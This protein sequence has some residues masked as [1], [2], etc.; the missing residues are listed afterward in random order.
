VA[1]LIEIVGTDASLRA[2][3]ARAFAR[4]PGEWSVVVL[5][6]PSGDADVVVADAT[7][8]S[9]EAVTFDPDRP[10]EAL[11]EAGARLSALPPRERARTLLVAGAAGG[12]GTTTLALHLAA[13]WGAGTCVCDVAG[14]AARSLGLPGDART[15]LPHDDDVA[16][17]ALPVAGGFRVL[18]APAPVP[19]PEHFP[20]AAARR[21]FQ[22]LVIEAGSGRDL[23]PLAANADAAVLVMPPTRPAA[24]AAAALLERHPAT[25]WAVVTNRCGPGGQIMRTGLEAVVGRP[26][27]LEL[28][29]CPA[30]RDAEDG[31]GLVTGRWHR[32]TRAV[33]RLARAVDAC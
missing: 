3:A 33:A 11:R 32:W 12:A 16:S 19:A 24:Q 23:E 6:E 8:A 30:L 27:A 21:S 1:P 5:D 4:A 26:I 9:G 22:R 7:A 28:P 14:G 18:C 29:C 10:D 25:R 15:W 13:T 2:A 17:A 31:G 20:L